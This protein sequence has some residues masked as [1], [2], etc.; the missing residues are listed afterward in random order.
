[1]GSEKGSEEVLVP[2]MSPWGISE[3]FTE[4]AMEN[5]VSDRLQ[6]LT[7]SAGIVGLLEHQGLS[8]TQLKV[9]NRWYCH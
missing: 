9:L 2:L 8:T 7:F 6:L 4:A 3:A 1:M 5:K